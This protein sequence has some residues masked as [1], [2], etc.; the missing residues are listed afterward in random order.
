[1]IPLQ[2]LRDDPDHFRRGAELKHEAAPV[3]E[4]LE[5]D[6]RARRLRNEVESAQAER[7]AAHPPPS[8]VPPPTSSGRSSPSSRPGCSRAR[9]SWASWRGAS[10]PLLLYVPNPPHESAPIGPDASGNVQIRTGGEPPHFDFEPRPHFELGD[11][12]GIFDFERAAKISGARFAILRGEGARLQRALIAWD[13]RHRDPRARLHRDPAALPGAGA[14]AWS[15]PPSCPSSRTTPTAPTTT[16]S[17]F[18]P[19]RCR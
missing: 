6:L 12:L 7:A 8:T 18:P 13:A 5:L 10:S 14:S 4:I 17:W 9:P 11:R 19:P 2:A 1:V 3:D 15:A 16:S